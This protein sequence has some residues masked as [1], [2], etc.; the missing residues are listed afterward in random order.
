MLLYFC[1]GFHLASIKSRKF[2]VNLFLGLN[3]IP[4]THGPVYY[5]LCCDQT[6]NGFPCAPDLFKAAFLSPLSSC[7]ISLSTSEG[8]LCL[9]NLSVKS[10]LEICW[11]TK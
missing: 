2:K 8:A 11:S 10:L 6:S 7:K 9:H 4:N 5:Y 3:N 1:Y